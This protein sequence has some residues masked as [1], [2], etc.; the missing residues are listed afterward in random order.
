VRA[1]ELL[2]RLRGDDALAPDAA[3]AVV[4]WAETSSSL[5]RLLDR[6]SV[7]SADERA[8]VLALVKAYL[9]SPVPFGPGDLTDQ[10][11]VLQ[12][13]LLRDTELYDQPAQ[14]VEP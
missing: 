1:G 14:E 7:I 13:R 11:Y 8:L 5:L 12:D 6:A 3:A 4:A 10:A 9:D 2:K